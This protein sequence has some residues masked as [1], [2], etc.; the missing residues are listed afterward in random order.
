MLVTIKLAGPLR[1]LYKEPAS[2]KKEEAEI[3]EGSSVGDLLE[4]YDVPLK[5]V[6]LIT[7][8]RLKANVDTRLSTG[9]EINV[10]PPAAGG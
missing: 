10:I 9:D 7:V 1:K 6:R 2:R 8:N 3:P 4:V 5:S